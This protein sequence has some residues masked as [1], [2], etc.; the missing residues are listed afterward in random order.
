VALRLPRRRADG[1][2]LVAA[3]FADRINALP[4]YVASTSLKEV[5]WSGARL[6]EGDLVD[7]DILQYGFGFRVRGAR[8]ERPARRAAPLGPS[9]ADR[10]RRPGQMLFRPGNRAK[11]ELVDSR[12]FGNGVIV[13]VNRPLDQAAW[14]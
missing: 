14:R 9:G 6:I 8:A 1:V 2:R 13:L 4:K 7:G 3:E 12:P 5:D 11:L 10:R